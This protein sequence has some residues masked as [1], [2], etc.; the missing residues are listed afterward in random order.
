M[1]CFQN[2]PVTRTEKTQGLQ[3]NSSSD[4]CSAGSVSYFPNVASSLMQ[5]HQSFLS[6]LITGWHETCTQ[7]VNRVYIVHMKV[8][9]PW[10]G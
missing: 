2:I 3:A 9:S 1:C 5:C 6:S 7:Q 4:I 8:V 10:T